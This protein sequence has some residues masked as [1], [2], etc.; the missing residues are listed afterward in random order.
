MCYFLVTVRVADKLA[1]LYSAEITTEVLCET[2]FVVTV[3]LA[4]VAPAG[5]RM[6]AGTIATLVLLL[7]RLITA[8]P[9][10]A[11][12][13]SVTVPVEV[14]PPLTLAGLTLSVLSVSSGMGV[15]VG[16]DVGVGVTVD[17]GVAVTVG[18]DAA[19]THKV[20]LTFE[21]L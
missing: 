3:K 16:V 18:V 2:R 13:L 21:L 12:A 4:D 20:A 7:A 11:G 15:D 9:E 19:P 1:L 10:G 8:P 6:L 5:T 14:N 17:I